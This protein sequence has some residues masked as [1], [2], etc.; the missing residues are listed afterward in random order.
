MIIEDFERVLLF[1]GIKLVASPWRANS[2][3]KF[4]IRLDAAL[5]EFRHGNAK[6]VAVSKA[7]FGVF[8]QGA[9]DDIS[10]S[11]GALGIYL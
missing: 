11:L 9:H 2:A 10:Q 7:L 3:G 1:C 8:R 5:S 4:A 6:H